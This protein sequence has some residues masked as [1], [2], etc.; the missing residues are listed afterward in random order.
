MFLIAIKVVDMEVYVDQANDT[1]RPMFRCDDTSKAVERTLNFVFNTIYTYF[2][3]FPNKCFC[4][5]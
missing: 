1:V 5:P 4:W 2:L 3:V